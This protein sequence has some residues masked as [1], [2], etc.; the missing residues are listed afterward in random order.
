MVVNMLVNNYGCKLF[1]INND[2]VEDFNVDM[3][4]NVDEGVIFSLAYQN[5]DG[6]N[7]INL[8]HDNSK[9]YF[10]TGKNYNQNADDVVHEFDGTDVTLNIKISYVNGTIDNFQINN[11]HFNI[12]YNNNDYAFLGQ[13]TGINN[14]YYGVAQVNENSMDYHNM[15][16][17]YLNFTY[18]DFVLNQQE[19]TPLLDNEPLFLYDDVEIDFDFYTQNLDDTQII[20]FKD[21]NG[22]VI[23]YKFAEL[24]NNVNEGHLTFKKIDDKMKIILNNSTLLLDDDIFLDN[25][26]GMS[27]IIGTDIISSNMDIT[28]F[29]IN[30][31]YSEFQDYG[32]EKRYNTFMVERED[33]T[34]VEYD[35]DGTSIQ[36]TASNNR[37]IMIPTQNGDYNMPFIIH[38]SGEVIFDYYYV[39]DGLKHN[40]AFISNRIGNQNHRI[41]F[42]ELGLTGNTR[43]KI[44]VTNEYEAVG[45]DDA[46]ANI[47][48]YVGEFGND[49]GTFNKIIDEDISISIVRA[50][51]Y[52]GFIQANKGVHLKYKNFVINGV[53]YDYN[54]VVVCRGYDE[55]GVLDDARIWE[56]SV[57]T[58]V[59]T[60]D[61]KLVAKFSDVPNNVK[62]IDFV[63]VFNDENIKRLEISKIM[64][65]DGL[66]DAMYTEDTREDNL[67]KITI[68]FDKNYYCN[69]YNSSKNDPVGLSI[70][71]PTFEGIS[72]RK[73]PAPKIT[74]D[75]GNQG[76]TVLYPYLKKADEE[77]K[78]ENVAIEYLNSTNQTIKLIYNG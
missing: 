38:G 2:I 30:S 35:I 11:G 55:R 12:D 45:N 78:P 75:D 70:I 72:L 57:V 28:N 10:Y 49:K 39:E 7:F 36:S 8:K 76:V 48:V 77:N 22:H 17:T 40:G 69:Y 29:V 20:R 6:I 42:D 31:P 43:I 25:L 9:W 50:G 23:D 34:E 58:T 41:Y 51:W 66:E 19:I 37:G 27:F 60:H 4:V 32:V 13:I 56:S 53:S 62:Y 68:N 61:R 26:Y 24:L 33:T 44:Q 16:L 74:D 18:G 54:A 15:T 63:I 14:L 73:L 21:Q 67:D 1:K 71:R 3:M 65:Y 52:F 59:N 5:N 46:N 47:K 64:L